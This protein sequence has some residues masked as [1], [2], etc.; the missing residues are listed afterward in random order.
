[1]AEN[2]HWIFIVWFNTVLNNLLKIK[3]IPD[4]I[5]III[6]II[7]ITTII[8]I[9]IITTDFLLK[10]KPHLFFLIAVATICKASLKV[11]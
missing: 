9:I 7:I 5:T 2:K 1:M 6:I 11:K 3:T 4:D 8:I 10:K